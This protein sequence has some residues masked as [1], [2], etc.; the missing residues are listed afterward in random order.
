VPVAYLKA[1]PNISNYYVGVSNELWQ[2]SELV[3]LR[4]ERA[5]PLIAG[6]ASLYRLR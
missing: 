4:M 1:G 3:G 2:Q 6:G 5:G